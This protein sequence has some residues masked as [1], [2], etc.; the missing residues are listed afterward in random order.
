L[1]ATS[2]A[3]VTGLISVALAFTLTFALTFALSLALT[4][5]LSLTLPLAL[6]FTLAFALSL[7]FTLALTRR[8]T[9]ATDFPRHAADGLRDVCKV[10]VRFRTKSLTV[11]DTLQPLEF[12]GGLFESTLTGSGVASIHRIRGCAQIFRK[13]L[14]FFSGDVGSLL[15]PLRHFSKLGLGRRVEVLC[16]IANFLGRGIQL[17]LEDFARDRLCELRR[18]Q[19]LGNAFQRI[20]QLSRIQRTF[21]QCL[22]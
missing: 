17:E 4:L 14:Q 20:R 1:F 19:S 10:R 3:A 8:L 16:D 15:K 18:I 13:L 5:T 6:A 11:E 2:A 21:R 22:L 9:V 12:L 7:P